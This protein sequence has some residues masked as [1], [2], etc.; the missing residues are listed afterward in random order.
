MLLLNECFVVASVCFIIDSV[1]RNFWIHPRKV[2]RWCNI[3]L[4]LSRCASFYHSI[5][6]SVEWTEGI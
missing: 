5:H 4:L 2:A 1:R 6:V 3:S